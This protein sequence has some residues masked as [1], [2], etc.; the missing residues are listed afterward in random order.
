MLTETFFLKV[1]PSLH[2]LTHA[3][4]E[5]TSAFPASPGSQIQLKKCGVEAPNSEVEIGRGM[6]GFTENIS[7]EFENGEGET[8]KGC[9]EKLGVLETEWEGE[10]RAV[11]EGKL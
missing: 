2:H 11:E 4:N 3:T 10:G 1:F 8:W 9:L 7:I 5:L 6:E